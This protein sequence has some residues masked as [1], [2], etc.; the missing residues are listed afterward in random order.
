MPK[1]VYSEINLHI[2]WHTKNNNPVIKDNI[3]NRLHHFLENKIRK[4]KEV[5]FHAIG[6]IEDHIH[7]VVSIPPTLRIS[8]WIGQLKGGSS[9]YINHE[10]VNRK[11]L[12]WQ[13][14]YGVVSFGTRD[15]E[16]VIQYVR[17]QKQHHAKGTTQERLE[18]ITSDDE[19]RPL[20][21]P[22]DYGAQ[23]N[24]P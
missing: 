16:W 21:R 6:G 23:V 3:E 10:I 17:N 11:L 12:D 1:N 14:G 13:E 22:K 24:Q 18:R 15:L 4:E 8:D 9:F 20:K 19:G 5:I 2:T 7:L